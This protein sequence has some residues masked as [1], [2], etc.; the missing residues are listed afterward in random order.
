MRQPIIRQWT[1]NEI[2]TLKTLVAKG[3]SPAKV[4]GVLKRRIEPVKDKARDVG[5]PFEPLREA[6]KRQAEGP[7]EPDSLSDWQR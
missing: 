5:A 6:R 4:A 7:I 3:A 2:E 1:E